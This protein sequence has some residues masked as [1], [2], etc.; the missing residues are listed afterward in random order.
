MDD[1]TQQAMQN[2]A[3]SQPG[4]IRSGLANTAGLG[5][6]MGVSTALGGGFGDTALGAIL[7]YEHGTGAG[8]GGM[9]KNAILNA[10]INKARRQALAAVTGG[11][12]APTGTRR[13]L[14]ALAS[15]AGGPLSTKRLM[16]GPHRE[17]SAA[18]FKQKSL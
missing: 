13:V 7:G 1:P 14:G 17:R 15:G 10:G 11:T 12:S 4:L 5:V 18:D 16:Q 8:F 3:G 2:L 9:A 6:N